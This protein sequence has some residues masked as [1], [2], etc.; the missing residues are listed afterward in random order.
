MIPPFENKEKSPIALRGGVGM[1]PDSGERGREREE[2]LRTIKEI[3]KGKGEV[4]SRQ[5]VKDTMIYP[6]TGW[7]KSELPDNHCEF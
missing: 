5:D 4:V 7:D 3:T 6:K 2:L 1:R